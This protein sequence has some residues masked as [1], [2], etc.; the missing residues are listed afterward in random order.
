MIKAPNELELRKAYVLA[1][2]SAKDINDKASMETII[3]KKEE[4]KSKFK[5]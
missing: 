2:N 4:L 3:S 1:Y 5:V